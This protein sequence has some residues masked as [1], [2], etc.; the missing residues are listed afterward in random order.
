LAVDLDDLISLFDLC[1]LSR[2]I[3]L[4]IRDQGWRDKEGSAYSRIEDEERQD[5]GEEIH[6]RPGQHHDS[7]DVPWLAKEFIRLVL[8]RLSALFFFELTAG[9]M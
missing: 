1:F 2:G 4:D 8:S 7:T 9:F 3:R 6:P 5:R